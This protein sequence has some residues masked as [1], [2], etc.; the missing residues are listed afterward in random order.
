MLQRNL[1]TSM[2]GGMYSPPD[3]MIIAGHSIAE[4]RQLIAEMRG[5]NFDS[6]R[7]ASYRLASKLRFIQKKTHLHLVDIWNVIE[8]F[9]ENG[10]QTLDLK[11]EIGIGRLEV[12]VSGLYYQLNKRLPTAR[13]VNIEACTN[14]LLNWLLYT[15]NAED[16]GRLRV[17]AIKVA[18]GILCS[19][20]L[21][22][23]LRYIFSQISDANGHMIANKFQEFLKDALALPAAV[24]ESPS[25][26]Y[27]DSMAASMFDGHSKVNVNEFLDLLM[28]DPGPP[29]LIWLP[30][31]H[32]VASVEDV[33]HPVPC[34]AC[35]R[36]SFNGFRYKCQRCCNYQLCQDCF[37]KGKTSKSHTVD[38]E[39][40]EYATFKSP[41]KQLG[42]SIR[43]SFRCVPD[44]RNPEIPRFPDEPEKT[45]NLSHIIPPSPM[46]AHKSFHNEHLHNS[47]EMAS[48]NSGSTSR[49]PTKQNSNLESN[50]VDDEHRLIA[51]YA[52]R[53]AADANHAAR[54]P[55]ELSLS[56]DTSRTQRELICR[57]EAKNREIMEEISRLRQQQ[58]MEDHALHSQ[59][60]PTLLAELKVLRQRK[61]EL[62]HHLSTLQESRRELMVQ[63]EGLMKLLKNHQA[64]P[65]S[66]PNSSPR[67]G[68]NQSPTM[69]MMGVPML[70]SSSRSA[71]S[72]PGT[73]GP[74]SSSSSA[75]ASAAAPP[76]DSLS[77]VG[78]DVR[79]AFGHS[80]S[81]RSLR[82]ELL[83][84]ADS[85]TNAMSSL[86]TELHS[87]EQPTHDCLESP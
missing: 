79:L 44:K 16:D 50:R 38:H 19:G 42:H 59:Q 43:K 87:G 56:L 26:A 68:S 81:T 10:F 18:L 73:V 69:S 70:S 20:K 31:L 33:E 25:F 84:A 34:D 82:S 54:S 7:F 48:I 71:P 2:N 13:Q 55:S 78:G 27:S 22:D 12:L 24:F 28:S 36:S 63:L 46:L 35:N 37:W 58:E 72:T 52:A 66:T 61:E 60:N 23:K 64:S 62:E 45:L 8:A 11:T 40:K 57:L 29:C 3:D 41:G 47:F 74:T 4:H 6:I 15:F 65:R 75:A 39:V 67:S 9:R 83:V 76:T 85:V 77:G 86:V 21:M 51:R 5:Q 80:G 17:F 53:L 32:R 1:A 14:L 49:S 30:L